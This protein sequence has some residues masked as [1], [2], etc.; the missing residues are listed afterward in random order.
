[1]SIHP[2]RCLPRSFVVANR[3][4]VRLPQNT[5][6][7]ALTLGL[8]DDYDALGWFASRVVRDLCQVSYLLDRL[9]T[10][11]AGTSAAFKRDPESKTA[12][13]SQFS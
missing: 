11:S 2:C 6:G 5:G 9:P 4:P 1:V 7:F 13:R 10:F 3:T 12:G 8:T